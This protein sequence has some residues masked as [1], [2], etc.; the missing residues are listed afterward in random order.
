MFKNAAFKYADITHLEYPD[1][2]FDIVVAGNVIH[3]LD[4]PLKALAELNRVCRPN[5]KMIIPTYMNREKRK[6]NVDGLVNIIGKAGADFKRQFTFS[7]YR[8]FFIDAGF[9]D[10]KITMADG[11]VP[12]AIVVIEK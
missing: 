5:G 10:V 7:S 9:K 11:C 6:G 8:Q 1:N 4:E 12:C 2:S 3:L